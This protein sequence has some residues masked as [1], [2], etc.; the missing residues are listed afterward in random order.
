MSQSLSQIYLHIVFS[1]KNRK[2]YLQDKHLRAKTHAY[3]AGIC[4]NLDSPALLVGGVEDHAHLLCRFSKNITV[5]VFLRELKRDSSKWIKTESDQVPDFHWQAGYGAFSISPS[6]TGV[7]KEYIARQEEHHRSE[8][9]QDEFRRL[10]TKYGV[11][12]DERY[13]W[14]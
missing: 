2:R 3:L 10:C 11:P 6:H 4:K 13:V 8:S 14:D 1:T 7:L 9:F 5:A 12:I